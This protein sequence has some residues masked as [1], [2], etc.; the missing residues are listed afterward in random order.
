MVNFYRRFVPNIAAI[1]RPLTDDLAGKPKEISWTI[2]M[3]R[4]FSEAKRAL[5]NTTQLTHY[6]SGVELHLLTDAST[7]AIAGVVHQLVDGE[8]RPLAFFSRRTSHAEARYSTYDLE[9]LAL[10]SSILH[11]RTLLEGVHFVFSLTR[12]H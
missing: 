8:K 6:V 9:L 5:A 3:E 2:H 12:N 11:C 1:L 10:Y 4:A 7:K